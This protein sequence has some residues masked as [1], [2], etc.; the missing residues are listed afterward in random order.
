MGFGMEESIPAV[1]KPN[2]APRPYPEQ[3]V[4]CLMRDCKVGGGGGEGGVKVGSHNLFLSFM[5]NRITSLMSANLT[6]HV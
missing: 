2:T 3:K 5:V 4:E 1:N 6:T